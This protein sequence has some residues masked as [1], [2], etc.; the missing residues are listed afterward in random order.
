MEISD[1]ELKKKIIKV[2]KVLPP[3]AKLLGYRTTSFKVTKLL[4]NTRVTPN[5]ITYLEILLS[6]L[7]VFL[8]STAQHLYMVIGGVLFQISIFLDYLDGDVARA[9]SIESDFGNWLDMFAGRV[10]TPGI[11]LGLTWAAFVQTNNKVA[12][13]LGALTIVNTFIFYTQPQKAADK[14]QPPSD[15]LR[16]KKKIQDRIFRIFKIKITFSYFA[17]FYILRLVLTMGLFF[18]Q[19]FFALI[20][21]AIWSVY[22]LLSFYFNNRWVLL[23]RGP[24]EEQTHA[25]R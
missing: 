2:G 19:L 24:E 5:Q 10:R 25:K 18:N 3:G 11:L 4:L 12:L 6:L 8:I 17:D 22:T 13:F 15:K 9:K 1:E 14:N 21:Y 16:L 20:Y 7:A 23:K